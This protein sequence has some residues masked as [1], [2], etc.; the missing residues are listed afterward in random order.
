MALQ[1]TV[2]NEDGNLDVRP[3]EDKKTP[4][5]RIIAITSGKG[6][7]G[8]TNV[9]TNLGIALAGLEKKVCILDADMGLANINILIGKNPDYTIED[10]LSGEK[11]IQ[12][13][14]MDGP[15]GIKIIP[16]SSGLEKIVE[17]GPERKERLVA[18]FEEIEKEF[19]YILIDTSAGISDTVLSFVQ[20]AQDAVIVV[21]PEPTSLT[22]A[23]ALIKI[24]KGKGFKG[25]TYVLV[26]MVLSYE[27]SVKIFS[28]FNAAAQKYLSMDLKYLGHVIMDQGM[29]AAVIQ[30]KPIMILKPDAIPSRCFVAI[31]RKF[32]STYAVN[33]TASFSQYWKGVSVDEKEIDPKGTIT[34][35]EEIREK[36]SRIHTL[37]LEDH[38]NKASE[39]IR[40]GDYSEDEAME[41]IQKIEYSFTRRFDKL[42]YDLKTALYS[43]FELSNF[44]EE[45]IKELN[46]FLESIYEQRFKRPL[47][48]IRETFIK[49]LEE[50]ISSEG[51]MKILLQLV[52]NSFRRRFK[53]PIYNLKE[54]LMAEMSREDFFEDGFAELIETIKETYQNRFRTPYK[55][56][57][58][59]PLADV[60][61][62]FKKM[63]EQDQESDNL[64]QKASDLS[65]KREESQNQLIKIISEFSEDE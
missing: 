42:P 37:S 41:S 2:L 8:K 3:L 63:K 29:I 16:A 14:L 24:L 11:G 39:M 26:N 30:Q 52:E 13:V 50:S 55:E 44:S 1:Q 51:K 57:S 36:F 17:L 60:E 23:Y 22:D 19:D 9:T 45:N 33:A 10:V 12:H 27:D 47:H 28:R 62:I 54:I 56:D 61:D 46:Q 48:S 6:G 65:K 32:E 25:N 40:A 49:L 21:S 18:D 7:V 35:P 38:V 53:K 34:P 20:S 5:A 58:L 31:A 64:I 4:T 43:S 15:G 59:F